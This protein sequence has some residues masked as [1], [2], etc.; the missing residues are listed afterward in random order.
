[1]MSFPG[2]VAVI[3]EA[4]APENLRKKQVDEL[5]DDIVKDVSGKFRGTCRSVRDQRNKKRFAMWGVDKEY[6]KWYKEESKYL[7]KQ[8]DF[9]SFS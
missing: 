5:V 3:A 1:M 8:F 6:Q 2:T 9:V 7:K 4:G